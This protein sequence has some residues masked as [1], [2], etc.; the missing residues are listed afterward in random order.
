MIIV[1]LKNY[2][3]IEQALKAYKHKHNNIGIIQELRERQTY[4]KPSIKRRNEL[5]IAKYVESK[6]KSDD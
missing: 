1:D 4:T 3:T 6:K 2:K 5:L